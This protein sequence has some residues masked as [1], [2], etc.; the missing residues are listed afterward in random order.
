MSVNTAIKGS[1]GVIEKACDVQMDY[2]GYIETS[3]VYVGHLA[4]W[5]MI[6]G[7][8]AHTALNTLIPAGLTPVTIPPE[9]IAHFAHKE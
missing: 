4:S 1:N 9:G 7:K 8:P 6:L 5:D 3:T 2:R